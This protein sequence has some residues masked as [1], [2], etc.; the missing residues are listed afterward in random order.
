MDA[1]LVANGT[2]LTLGAHS[3]VLANHDVL[4]RDGVIE[5]I[6]PRGTI[7]AQGARV[8]DASRRVVMPGFINAHTHLYSTFA[9][10]I[11]GLRS[12]TSF[13]EVLEH[14]WWRL[15]RALA[16]EDCGLSALVAM[17]DAVRHG[18]TTLIDHHAS[19]S[20]VRGSL[21][22][23]ASAAMRVGV[24]ACL[25]YEVSDRDGERVAGEGI[26]ENSRFVRRC[27][28]EGGDR[29]RALFGLHASFTVSDATLASVAEAGKRLGA[30][31][32]V[33][34][35]E[36]ASDQEHAVRV[37]GARVIER[38]RAFDVL[39]PRTI[40]AHCVHVDDREMEVLA[41]TGTT[42]IHN[43]QSNM[44]NAVGAADVRRLQRHGV[45]VGLGTDAMTENM[46]EELRAAL[47]LRHLTQA[48]PSA[49]FADTVSLLLANNAAI[50]NRHWQGRL[51]EVREGALA[52]L[53]VID[54]DPPTPLEE[55]NLGGH[56]VFGLSQ[57]AVDATIVGGRVLMAGRRL[58]LDL[59]EAELAA[60]ARE[61]ARAL[62]ERL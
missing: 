8:L 5:R 35:A 4:C 9:R 43:P 58:E 54:Y 3:R 29:L 57:A 18:T 19:P 11:T 56:V 49:G 39:G 26:E 61:R 32:H 23:I 33:H 55:G 21:D 27:Q 50:A 20:A 13:R 22:V 17:T 59:D 41:A 47:W 10:G 53:V 48:D 34:A 14:L 15:D 2:V 60:H 1:L 30:G 28:V 44:N 51:G 62:W 25:C 12:S 46:L 37:F 16:L 40:A 6:A 24:R 31:F 45:L 7:D 42:V 38:F 36:A 52:D